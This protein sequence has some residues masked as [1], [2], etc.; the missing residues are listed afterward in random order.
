MATTGRTQ[1]SPRAPAAPTPAKLSPEGERWVSQTLKNM[2]LDEKIGQLFAV[3]AYG[4]F[5]STESQDY[6]DLLRDVEEKHIGSFAIQT[7]GSPLGVERSQVYPTAVLV[8][9]L[10]SHAK[11]P[12]LVGRGFRA[13]HVHAHRGRHVVSSR[14]GRRRHRPP[15]RRL[16]DGK[17]YGAR[18]EG[19]GRSLDFCARCRREQQSRKSHHQHALVWRR[20]RAR[21][22]ICRRLRARGRGKRRP[23]HRE[24]FPRPRRHQH[25]FASR[26]AHA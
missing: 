7:Q 25:R 18:S 8:N 6:K 26:S 23:G 19:G 14:N 12:L 11:V 1:K 13:R 15:R 4:A 2:S 9:T 3:W 5:I 21:F 10:Q 17:N 24:T 16:H 22:G 20:S